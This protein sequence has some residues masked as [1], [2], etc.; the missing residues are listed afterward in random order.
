MKEATF[1]CIHR[2]AE[3]S[4][5]LTIARLGKALRNLLFLFFVPH[6]AKYVTKY[7]SQNIWV[8]KSRRMTGGT[9]NTNGTDDKNVLYHFILKARSDLLWHTEADGS[10]V[11]QDQ[12]HA[13]VAQHST[14]V[15]L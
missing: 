7:S 12:R 11:L 1:V 4:K 3:V 9:Y 10:K 14:S 5:F 13:C 8:T 6:P 2:H 15:G